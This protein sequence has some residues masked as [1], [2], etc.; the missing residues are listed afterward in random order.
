MLGQA[1]LLCQAVLFLVWW[2]SLIFIIV[3]H[4]YWA[5]LGFVSL[6][7]RW[8]ALVR[9]RIPGW[10]LFQRFDAIYAQDISRRTLFA[11]YIF[12][13]ITRWSIDLGWFDIIL[14]GNLNAWFGILAEFPFLI[15]FNYGQPVHHLLLLELLHA[16]INRKQ[17]GICRLLRPR[18]VFTK[19][20]MATSRDTGNKLMPLVDDF[21]IR[22]RLVEFSFRLST[23]GYRLL[24]MLPLS[25][26]SRVRL[27]G[28]LLDD[29]LAGILLFSVVNI[30]HDIVH[31]DSGRIMQVLKVFIS[32]IWMQGLWWYR[33]ILG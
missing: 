15:K 29:V 22:L 2:F 26:M 23:E 31:I 17:I 28:Q 5:S 19:R 10:S 21:G 14:V 11:A 30:H 20:K 18:I 24:L 12:F 4:Y 3:P 27:L 6:W 1:G 25:K 8:P 9:A 13:W 32:A 33:L 16:A 7:V